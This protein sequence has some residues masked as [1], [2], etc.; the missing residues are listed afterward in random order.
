MMCSQPLPQNQ[1]A[2]G[3]LAAVSHYL[4]MATVM[5]V[6]L[7]NC[8]TLALKILWTSWLGYSRL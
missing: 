2:T 6:W 3:V 5:A 8:G 1:H 4:R 7:R